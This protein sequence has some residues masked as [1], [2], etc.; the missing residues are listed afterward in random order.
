MKKSKKST[1]ILL[2][3]LIVLMIGATVLYD[4][5]SEVVDVDQPP[6]GSSSAES[7]KTEAVDFTMTDSDG[8][9]VALSD[10]YGKPIVLNFWASWCPPCKEE[11]PHFQAMYDEYGDD[12][13]FI[14]LNATD[15][16]RE[17]KQDADEFI[18]E[19]GYTFPVLY[20]FAPEAGRDVFQLGA[21]VY[22]ISS[23]PTTLFIDADG[24]IESGVRGPISEEQ[25]ESR[26]G[27][28]IV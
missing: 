9:V 20:D 15:G 17:K 11:M 6:V 22:G 28:I 3:G 14:M 12:V 18:A 23:L 24:F 7:N 8:N 1:V 2:G 16:I 25:L 5:L 13:N 26:I 19:T 27:E 21:Y 4:S 10:Y